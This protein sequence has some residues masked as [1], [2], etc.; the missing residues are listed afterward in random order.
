MVYAKLFKKTVIALLLLS[1]TVQFPLQ[2]SPIDLLGRSKSGWSEP[3]AKECEV[4]TESTG[5]GPIESFGTWS[6]DSSYQSC[7][8]VFLQ[9]NFEKRKAQVSQVVLYLRGPPASA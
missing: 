3:L 9:K 7:V 5:S 4:E 2:Q 6:D 1:L 8:T